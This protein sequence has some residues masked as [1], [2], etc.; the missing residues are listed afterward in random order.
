MVYH[1][2][3]RTA[4]ACLRREA[5]GHTLQS[6]DL[7]NEAYLKLLRGQGQDWHDRAHF[8]ATAARAMRRILVDH[9]R[10]RAADKRGGGKP[11]LELDTAFVFSDERSPELLRLDDALTELAENDPREC[12]IVEMRFF[13]GLTFKEIAAVLGISER[14]VKR[15][16]DHAKAWLYG[17]LSR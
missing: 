17:Q 9:A 12:H 2:L 13:V 16:W 7:V 6:T 1:D 3:K 11:Q 10:K 5:P 8:F 15:D 4:A 14:T